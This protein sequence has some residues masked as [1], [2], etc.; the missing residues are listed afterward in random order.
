MLLLRWKIEK[1]L[2][3]KGKQCFNMF[4]LLTYVFHVYDYIV[5]IDVMITVLLQCEAVIIMIL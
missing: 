3:K 5:G 1:S 4:D 2:K